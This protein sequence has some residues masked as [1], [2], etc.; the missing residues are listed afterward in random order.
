MF[1]VANPGV[2]YGIALLSHQVGAFLGAFLGG[3]TFAWTGAS[4]AIFYAVAAAGVTAALF[5]LPIRLPAEPRAVPA[6]ATAMCSPGRATSR[7]PA[8]SRP[9]SP[10]RL[11]AAT[12]RKSLNHSAS[13]AGGPT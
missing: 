4:D 5:N 13:A 8:L 9:Y 1:G 10:V 2:L 7:D 12:R 6:Q 11:I 3:L